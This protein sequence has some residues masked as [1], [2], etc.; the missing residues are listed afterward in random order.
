[1][2]LKLLMIVFAMAS[3]FFPSESDATFIK[4]RAILKQYYNSPDIVIIASTGRS[5]S[6]MLTGQVKKYD[7]RDEILKTHLL[8]PDQ[9]FKGKIIFIFSNPDK[10]SESALYLTFVS[11]SFMNH[12]HHVETA[13]K[14]WIKKI[15]GK[16][17]LENNL[18]SYDAL[19]IH[20]HLKVWL[21][22]QTQPADPANAQILAIKYENLWDEET[23]AA[24]KDFLAVP[25]FSLPP[26]KPRGSSRKKEVPDLIAFKKMYNLGTE[27]NP[28]YAAYDDARVLW[29]Q[30]PP[31]QYLEIT[32][33][34]P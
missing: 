23:V 27:S 20:E 24:I 34:D 5:G 10:A 21:Y 4:T 6:T 26:K 22:T 1:M 8:P 7:S 16:Q 12:F 29:E 14:G 3:L 30:A 19:G 13:E 9:S 18:L 25:D 32:H 17:T 11:K 15:G 33:K 28:R 2:R 31:F